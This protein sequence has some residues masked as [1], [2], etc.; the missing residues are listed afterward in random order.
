M[1]LSLIL[2]WMLACQPASSGSPSVVEAGA[3]PPAAKAPAATADEGVV[4]AWQGGQLTYGEI[5][6]DIS[7]DL[8]KLEAE[9]LTNRY[10]TEMGALDDKVNTALLDLEAKKAGLSDV[11]ALLKR[12]I[13]DKTPG[14]TEAEIK[15]LY[16]ANAR[17][18][19]GKTIDDVRPDLERA[20]KQQKQAERFQVYMAELRT[21][22]GL[23]LQLPFPDLPR[24]NVSVDDD[25]SVGPADAPVTIIQF[26]EYQCPYC[27]T[28]RKSLEQV[29]KAYP[30]KVRLVFRDF[31][32]GFHDRAIPAAV[33]ANCAEKQGKY[34]E[35]HDAL[36]TNQRALEE[37]DLERVAREA[38]LD[39]EKW[40]ACRQDPAMEDE[41]KKDMADG[42]EAG[43][44][45]TPAF[46][47]NGVF[48][49]GALPFERFK[50]VI[51]RELSKG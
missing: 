51:D 10:D 45:G 32:L 12:E 48:L 5:K 46:F 17:K 14:A 42:T 13:E 47:V 28:A 1:L 43:V 19:R 25:P 29:E 50:A 36:M 4:A 7:S 23:N 21:A 33:A 6:K 27:G 9:Y 49:N 44:S 30:G 34:W 26:A 41:I 11:G 40:Q 38:K 8:T 35:V 39:L 3:P 2:T 16:D 37:A 24:I 15:E 20:V 18:L 31:P 22:Y